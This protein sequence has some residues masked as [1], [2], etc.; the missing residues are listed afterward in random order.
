MSADTSSRRIRQL[1]AHL[2]NTS[3]E[4]AATIATTM[5]LCDFHDL[6]AIEG[7]PAGCAWNYYAQDKSKR[8]QL[9]RKRIQSYMSHALVFYLDGV[10]LLTCLACLRLHFRPEPPDIG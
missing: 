4:P 6:P 3:E 7:Q 2:D 8:D 9:G 1:Q 10:R 5:H